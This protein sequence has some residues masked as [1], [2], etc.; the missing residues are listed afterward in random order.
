MPRAVVQPYFAPMLSKQEQ[1][2]RNPQTARNQRQHEIG[3]QIAPQPQVAALLAAIM[4]TGPPSITGSHTNK[5]THRPCRSSA[6]GAVCEQVQYVHGVSHEHLQPATDRRPALNPTGHDNPPLKKAGTPDSYTSPAI[7]PSRPASENW[8]GGHGSTRHRAR[9]SFTH[10]D[11]GP[12]IRSHWL[13]ICHRGAPGRV[14]SLPANT[15]LQDWPRQATRGAQKKAP[16][17]I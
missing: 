12:T 10:S 8:T 6:A 13:S 7:S 16:G 2:C 1:R 14:S 11:T 15:K 3:Q 9:Q 17:A 5:T 4:P